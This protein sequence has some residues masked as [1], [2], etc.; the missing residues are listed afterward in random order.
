MATNPFYS[1]FLEFITVFENNKLQFSK[2]NMVDYVNYKPTELTT[3]DLDY[4]NILNSKCADFFKEKC[5][6]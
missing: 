2:S 1:N 5:R 4:N 6:S 3:F